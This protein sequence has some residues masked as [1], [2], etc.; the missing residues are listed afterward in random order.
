MSGASLIVSLTLK[1]IFKVS[2]PAE[3]HWVQGLEILSLEKTLFH[4]FFFF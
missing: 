3:G 2:H 1:M 4:F